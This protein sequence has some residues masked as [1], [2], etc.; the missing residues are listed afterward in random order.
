MPPSSRLPS[1]EPRGARELR[2]PGEPG[3]LSPLLQTQTSA[4]GRLKQKTHT[5]SQVSAYFVR[6]WYE[7]RRH[8]ALARASSTSI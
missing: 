5:H 7:S 1:R 8:K 6:S 2:E 3:Q 4:I